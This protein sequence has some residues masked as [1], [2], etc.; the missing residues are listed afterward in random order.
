MDNKQPIGFP[1][2]D[3]ETAI[4][5]TVNYHSMKRCAAREEALITAS[6]SGEFEAGEKRHKTARRRA[7][8]G[9]CFFALLF[10]YLIAYI[11]LTANPQFLAD[12]RIKFCW[13]AVT[14]LTNFFAGFLVAKWDP[15]REVRK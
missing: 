15:L 13:V 14:L 9:I 7:R 5:D 2:P 11:I 8:A 1:H 6:L 12:L 10:T 4:F 3:A